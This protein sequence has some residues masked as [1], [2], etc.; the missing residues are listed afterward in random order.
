MTIFS[1]DY[2]QNSISAFTV[3]NDRNRVQSQGVIHNSS[4]AMM[5]KVC[6][7][8]N[9]GSIASICAET[10]IVDIGERGSRI[11]TGRRTD[12]RH[13]RQKYELPIFRH[14]IHLFAIDP[15]HPSKFLVN[16]YFGIEKIPTLIAPKPP[17]WTSTSGRT[18]FFSIKSSS[19]TRIKPAPTL[20][21]L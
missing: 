4:D 5:V 6:I 11:I 15:A 14:L 3:L 7:N 9:N 10:R 1:V 18:N 12:L 17:L 16:S 8:M 13:Y 21:L 2:F 20:G 19:M